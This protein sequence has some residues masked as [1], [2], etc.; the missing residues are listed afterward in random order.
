MRDDDCP[1][2]SPCVRRCCLNAE[3]VCLGCFRSLEEILQWAAA[4]DAARAA[5][6]ANAQQRQ[7]VHKARRG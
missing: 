7:A 4:D 5:M 3:E 2:A 1:V 6:L